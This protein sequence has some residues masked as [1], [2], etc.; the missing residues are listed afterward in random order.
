MQKIILILLL[1]GFLLNGCSSRPNSSLN[2]FSVD[3]NFNYSDFDSRE[4]CYFHLIQKEIVNHSTIS[5]GSKDYLI[6]DLELYNTPYA[7]LKSLGFDG[8][9]YLFVESIRGST[10]YYFYNTSSNQLYLFYEDWSDPTFWNYYN[11][12]P[13]HPPR[14]VSNFLSKNKTTEISTFFGYKLG[15]FLN[16]RDLSNK[17]I[18]DQCNLNLQ[19]YTGK[20]ITQNNISMCE[21]I[22]PF[23]QGSVDGF[24]GL[25]LNP[26]ENCKYWYNKSR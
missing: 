23:I 21:I 22:P 24:A 5:Y 25:P 12:C 10:F 6:I 17:T 2:D 4:E 7:S 11:T 13:E 20:A 26:I 8:E 1:F 19:C 14:L 3:T 15:I 18:Y 16:N 9:T